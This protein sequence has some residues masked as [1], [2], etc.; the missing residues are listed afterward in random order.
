MTQYKEKIVMRFRRYQ[1]ND[2]QKFKD[3]S[4]YLENIL[5]MDIVQMIKTYMKIGEE[6]ALFTLNYLNIDKRWKQ[7]ECLNYSELEGLYLKIPSDQRIIL[8]YMPNFTNTESSIEQITRNMKLMIE[9]ISRYERVNIK[10]QTLKR[11]SSCSDI[12]KETKP[13]NVVKQ[14]R[15][16][17]ESNEQDLSNMYL[18]L[19]L[20]RPCRELLYFWPHY[21]KYIDE[22]NTNVI[23]RYLIS[24]LY[25]NVKIKK[26]MLKDLVH[27]I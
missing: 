19:K 21:T 1:Y 23:R 6:K 11:T 24:C 5:N 7:L 8:Y 16:I 2:L 14:F 18:K 10:T 3:V 22:K 12:Q 15:K 9:T 26:D 17:W 25:K 13:D 20:N 27:T 4:V